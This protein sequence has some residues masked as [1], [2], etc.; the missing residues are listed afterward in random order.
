[1]IPDKSRKEWKEMISGKFD[2]QLTSLSL[3]LKLN[4]LKLDCFKLKIKDV[5]TAANDLHSFCTANELLCSKDLN[6][7]F[8]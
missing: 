8:K 4:S 5:D 6:N 2:S 3:K 1:M 7:I